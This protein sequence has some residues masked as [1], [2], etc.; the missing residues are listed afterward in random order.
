[1]HY[2]V[3]TSTAVS[4]SMLICICHVQADPNSVD[5]NAVCAPPI[6]DPTDCNGNGI[7][8]LVD[9][10][11]GVLND[12]NANGIPDECET[13]CP[14][15]ADGDVDIADLGIVL[16]NFGSA[17]PPGAFGDLDGDGDVDIADLG[18]VLSN[19]GT[20]CP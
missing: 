3:R 12:M 17:V 18:L 9:I 20:V 4:V 2:L 13:P 14:G 16:S 5:P 7:D 6:L 1:M 8:D 11:N 10:A 19:F 15:D